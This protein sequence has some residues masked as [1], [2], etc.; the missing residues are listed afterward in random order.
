MGQS[1]QRSCAVCQR[2]VE[3][4][5][6]FD[7]DTPVRNSRQRVRFRAGSGQHQRIILLSYAAVCTGAAE[8][9]GPGGE[10]KMEKR[11][12]PAPGAP[13]DYAIQ[14]RDGKRFSPGGSARPGNRR[15]D[16]KISSG[17]DFGKRQARLLTHP[18]ARAP[19][20]APVHGRKIRGPRDLQEA[21]IGSGAQ[22][23]PARRYRGAGHVSRLRR[24]ARAPA[25]SQSSQLP[26]G[27]GS[28]RMG[29][30]PA[31]AGGSASSTGTGHGGAAG[32]AP[33]PAPQIPDGRLTQRYSGVIPASFISFDHFAWSARMKRANSSGASPAGSAPR[34]SIFSRTSRSASTRFTSAESFATVAAGV[35]AGASRPNH[36]TAS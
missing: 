14:D 27:G 36:P 17:R 5:S 1:D 26:K 30:R 18:R 4:K 19:V 2:V 28:H 3:I 35:A 12:T 10:G 25:G 16:T 20:E 31:P 9:A 22:D 15:R 23:R 24:V 11:R 13:R 21:R 33:E 8:S 6:N 32:A 29:E 34:P 7:P